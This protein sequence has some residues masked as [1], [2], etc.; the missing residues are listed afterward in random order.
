MKV[1]EKRI[2]SKMIFWLLSIS[3]SQKKVKGK[4]DKDICKKTKIGKIIITKV[5]FKMMEL[6]IK[7]M[8]VYV[9]SS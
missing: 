6:E 9:F 8:G 2:E 4:K 3:D 5:G 1:S 7:N